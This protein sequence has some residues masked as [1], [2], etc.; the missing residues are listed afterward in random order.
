[1]AIRLDSSKHWDSLLRYTVLNTN[2]VM[3]YQDLITDHKDC[4]QTEWVLC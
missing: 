4:K 1:M 3:Q 2:G